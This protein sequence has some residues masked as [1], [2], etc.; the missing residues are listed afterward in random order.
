MKKRFKLTQEFYKDN[1][2]RAVQKRK[3]NIFKGLHYRH[4]RKLIDL[5]NDYQAAKQSLN[6]F[7]KDTIIAQ[8]LKRTTMQSFCSNG[9]RNCL[10]P[11][12]ILHYIRKTG[13]P[14][15]TQAMDLT[16]QY[17][18]PFTEQDFI[19]FMISHETGIGSFHKFQEIATVK[20]CIKNIAK[21][22][23]TPDFIKYL[24][25]KL[26]VTIEIKKPKKDKNCPF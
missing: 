12:I 9:D 18:V 3:D 21:F 15:D 24:K 7:D 19:S 5:L 25:L 23:A 17:G 4:R 20:D 1:A 22:N 8:E 6:E 14:L 13:R 10:T 11:S 26:A 16:E 2:R